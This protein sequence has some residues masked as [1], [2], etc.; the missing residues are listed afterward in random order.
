MYVITIIIRLNSH[1]LFRNTDGGV[2]TT[3]MPANGNPH[4]RIPVNAYRCDTF[5]GFHDSFSMPP[6]RNA[7]VGCPYRIF[8]RRCPNGETRQN[9]RI[10]RCEKWI[11][12]NRK[13]IKTRLGNAFFF[14]TKKNKHSMLVSTINKYEDKKKIQVTWIIWEGRPSID[15]TR[16]GTLISFF[17]QTFTNTM[18]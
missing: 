6:E 17:Q 2:T 3:V 1:C 9:K 13:Y 5:D 18:I 12:K 7:P 16:H 11:K 10:T 15:G 14:F 4:S 8:D